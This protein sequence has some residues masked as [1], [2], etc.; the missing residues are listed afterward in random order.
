L[1]EKPGNRDARYFLGG[2]EGVLAAFALTIDHSRTEAFR[3]GKKAY[4]HHREIVDEQPDYYDAYVT[5]G[6]YEYIVANLPWYL[7]WIAQIAGYKGSEERAFEYLRLA[8]TKSQFISVNAH[9]ALVVLYLREQLYRQALDNAQFLQRRY[10]RNFLFELNGAGILTRMNRFDEAAAVYM[11]VIA[12]AEALTPNYHKMPLGVL[13][14]SVGKAL[15]NMDRLDLAQRVFLSAIQDPATGQR[16]R[17]L[18]QLCLAEILDLRGNREQAIANYQQV[19][20]VANFEDSRNA[21][22]AYLKTPY[23]RTR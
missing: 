18:S 9:S 2:A 22:Q 6:L 11:K 10:P 16:E 4:K 23:R 13:R 20:S 8:A 1:K 3:H 21:A 12:R 19:L 5:I 17:T 15:M 7:K 14:Y